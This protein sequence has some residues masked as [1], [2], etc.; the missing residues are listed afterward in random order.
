M[1]YGKLRQGSETKK[2]HTHTHRDVRQKIVKTEKKSVT[3]VT[4]W[5]GSPNAVLDRIHSE[6]LSGKSRQ[7]PH[8]AGA[9]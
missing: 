6:P 8:N 5:P 7:N 9:R 2:K 1:A 4:G 3:F